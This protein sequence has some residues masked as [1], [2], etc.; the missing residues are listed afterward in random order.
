MFS[1]F[2][3]PYLA[4]AFQRRPHNRNLRRRSFAV[5][6]EATKG[7]WET[8]SCVRERRTTRFAGTRDRIVAKCAAEGGPEVAVLPGRPGGAGDADPAGHDPGGR[9]PR[10]GRRTSR[11]CSAISA[12]L[13]A[14]QTSP[15]VAVDPLDP[16]KMVAVWVD[17]DPTML[18]PT[19]NDIQ[20]VLEAAYSVNGGQ[21]WLPLLGEPTN[22]NGIPA[23]PELLD[24]TTSG[25]TVPYKYV[26]TPSLGFDDSGN[27]YILSRV[28]QC[29]HGRRLFQRRGGAAEVQ[30]HR[31]HADRG[32]R[33]PTTSRPR[34][35]TA[36]VAA[37]GGSD[38]KV[39][40]QW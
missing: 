38:L 8:W 23:D 17:N 2:L 10:R 21:S 11:H 30:L 40:Y 19:N 7:E 28:P 6:I 1:R 31:V 35:P 16:S 9:R 4:S 32:R 14:S 34:I 18:R 33:S 37:S 3:E 26:T 27:F 25:P 15:V 5:H 22:G 36:A 24:P 20:V 39:I 12:A 13:N 29:R